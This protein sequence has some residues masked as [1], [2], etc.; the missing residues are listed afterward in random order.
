MHQLIG[1]LDEEG[2]FGFEYRGEGGEEGFEGSAEDGMGVR[3]RGVVGA[4]IC[5]GE[6]RVG[7]GGQGDQSQEARLDFFDLKSKTGGD[8]T[9]VQKDPRYPL[10]IFANP[11]PTAVPTKTNL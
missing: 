1:T 7:D 8:C 10:I 6:G 2:E 4:D 9:D 5:S 3:A 11:R